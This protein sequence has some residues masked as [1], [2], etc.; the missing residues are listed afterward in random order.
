MKEHPDRSLPLNRRVFEGLKK[1]PGKDPITNTIQETWTRFAVSLVFFYPTA[2]HHVYKQWHIQL[3]TMVHGRYS[4]ITIILGLY[5]SPSVAPFCQGPHGGPTSQ[6]TRTGTSLNEV[7]PHIH[8]EF[9]LSNRKSSV[10]SLHWRHNDHDGV[11]N[12]QPHGCLLNRLFRRRSKKKSKLRVTGL[13]VGNSPWPVN[14]PHKGPVTRKM[15]PFDDVIMVVGFL[16]AWINQVY[17]D[18][19]FRHQ[20]IHIG[21]GD[22]WK[23]AQPFTYFVEFNWFADFI[24]V[25]HDRKT[26]LSTFPCTEQ[27]KRP[28]CNS[29]A[30]LRVVKNMAHKTCTWFSIVLVECHECFGDTLCGD[31]YKN[32]CF[33]LKQEHRT[34]FFSCRS[35]RYSEVGG[36]FS[37]NLPLKVKPYTCISVISL[38]CAQLGT[39]FSTFQIKTEKLHNSQRQ[40]HFAPYP[41]NNQCLKCLNIM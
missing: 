37:A 5:S 10:S 36:F 26:L 28:L 39:A 27:Y 23:S 35:E 40:V 15:F 33:T 31:M 13:G 2:L 34:I 21:S 4:T 3:E 9:L 1:F 12:H 17:C 11:S 18:S 22:V 16:L 41:L 29:V 25:I 24:C 7:V 19:A 32:A 6:L 38:A 8:D 14:S 30:F 20:W